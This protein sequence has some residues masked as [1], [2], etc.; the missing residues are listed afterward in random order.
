MD[1]RPRRTQLRRGIEF[2]TQADPAAAQHRA[3]VPRQH[4][5]LAGRPPLALRRALTERGRLL[6]EQPGV[7][8]GL[9][10]HTLGRIAR[11][12]LPVLGNRERL[13][14]VRREHADTDAHAVAEQRRVH[15]GAPLERIG[16]AK[17][18]RGEHGGHPGERAVLGIRHV[19]V[20]LHRL[21]LERRR[22]RQGA[23]EAGIDGGVGVDDD[24]GVVAIQRDLR[25][26]PGNRARFAGP[27]RIVALETHGAAGRGPLRRPVAAVVGDHDNR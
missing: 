20:R 4:R 7:L 1:D 3:E 12:Q 5:Q 6:R 17:V 9:N 18:G 8:H 16:H 10:R 15:A 14:S 24:H 19:E 21:V 11:V 23:R 2:L 27:G 26:R 13:P 22:P 25:Q